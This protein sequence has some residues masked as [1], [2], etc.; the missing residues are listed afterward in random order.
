MPTQQNKAK[1]PP[2][3]VV[4]TNPAKSIA[5]ALAKGFYPNAPI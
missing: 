5:S 2:K 4:V 1:L 3:G